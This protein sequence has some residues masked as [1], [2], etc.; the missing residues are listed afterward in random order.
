MDPI[1]NLDFGDTEGQ[2]EAK[3]YTTERGLWKTL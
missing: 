2:G 3:S 1:D